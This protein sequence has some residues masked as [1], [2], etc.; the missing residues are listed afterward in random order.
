MELVELEQII[1]ANLSGGMEAVAL[2]L[3][4]VPGYLIV[5]YCAGSEIPKLHGHNT[6][7]CLFSNL[8]SG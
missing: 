2:Y 4:I 3:T 5:A 6:F 7:L 1:R 8:C